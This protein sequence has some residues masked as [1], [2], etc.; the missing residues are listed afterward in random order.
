MEKLEKMTHLLS[1]WMSL[2]SHRNREAIDDRGVYSVYKLFLDST[3]EKCLKR[4]FWNLKL[5]EI[6]IFFRSASQSE[7]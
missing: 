6:K 2:L 7:I 4:C 5:D 1:V 3:S